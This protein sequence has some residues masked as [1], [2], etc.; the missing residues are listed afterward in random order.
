MVTRAPVGANKGS[1][2]EGG[3]NELV[4]MLAGRG[5]MGP[6]MGRPMTGI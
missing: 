5:L 4:G 2:I 6:M 1:I 3:A